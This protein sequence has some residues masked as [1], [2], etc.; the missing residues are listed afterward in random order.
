VPKSQN[1]QNWSIELDKVFTRWWDKKFAAP[2]PAEDHEEPSIQPVIQNSPWDA[3]RN[4]FQ[5]KDVTQFFRDRDA[6]DPKF[7]AIY[8][9]CPYGAGRGPWDKEPTRNEMNCLAEE[10][11]KHSRPGTVFALSCALDQIPKWQSQFGE[12]S[13][14]NLKWHICKVPLISIDMSQMA[15]YRNGLR[16]DFKNV[17][18]YTL[19]FICVVKGQG[20]R[21]D[22]ALVQASKKEKSKLLGRLA[23]DFDD[24]YEEQYEELYDTSEPQ[25][26]ETLCQLNYKRCARDQPFVNIVGGRSN[27]FDRTRK[28]IVPFPTPKDVEEIND[29]AVP[30]CPNL[31][32]DAVKKELEKYP[33]E[34][35]TFRGGS[36]KGI[37]EIS[38]IISMICEP[39]S[40]VCLLYEGSG[41][42]S[43]VCVM[44]GRRSVAVDIDPLAFYATIKRLRSLK[45][46]PASLKVCLCYVEL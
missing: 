44:L 13:T 28:E 29:L 17:A 45:P 8:G 15:T 4:T 10:A 31:T 37:G 3:T 30:G 12:V 6:S 24:Q 33:K 34:K 46:R 20:V 19:L 9:D 38:Q 32:A 35:K 40:L 25:D 39:A 1:R 2:A 43:D 11:L 41:T 22:V 36:Q 42:A 7:D 27:K 18:T 23:A 26:E 14:T 5:V 16:L 21:L